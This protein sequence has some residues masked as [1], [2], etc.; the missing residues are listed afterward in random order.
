M[1]IGLPGDTQLHMGCWPR[2]DIVVAVDPYHRTAVDRVV[3]IQTYTTILVSVHLVWI[4][5]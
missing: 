4:Q 2:V 1:C 3:W 5:T